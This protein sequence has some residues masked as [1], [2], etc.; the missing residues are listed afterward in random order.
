MKTTVVSSSQ[1]NLITVGGRHVYLLFVNMS[2]QAQM[3]KKSYIDKICKCINYSVLRHTLYPKPMSIHMPRAHPY[4]AMHIFILRHK[5]VQ[6]HPH[7]HICTEGILTTLWTAPAE[8]GGG[9]C[10]AVQQLSLNFSSASRASG[11]QLHWCFNSES[12]KG[13]ENSVLK[14]ACSIVRRLNMP[15]HKFTL[16]WFR[17][18][19]MENETLQW[20]SN[21]R[22]IGVLSLNPEIN[23]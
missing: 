7:W 11:I 23:A 3:F 22:L 5:C 4:V 10:K 18:C 13:N 21:I 9:F 16:Y 1:L 8:E 15:Q 19:N 17:D 6:T 2:V 14:H 20:F 12:S